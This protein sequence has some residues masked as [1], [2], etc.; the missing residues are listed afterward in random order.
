MKEN[1]KNQLKESFD[2]VLGGGAS[3]AGGLLSDTLFGQIAPGI[4]TTILSYKQKRSEKMLFNA[5][6]QLKGRIVKIE[7]VIKQMSDIEKT[8]I[9]E[10]LIPIAF[11]SITEEI[12]EEKIK[13]IINGINTAIENKVSN[14]DIIIAYYDVLNSLRLADIRILIQL[15]KESK[16]TAVSYLI[17]ENRNSMNKYEAIETHILRKLESLCLASIQKTIGDLQGDFI[18]KATPDKVRIS[19]LGVQFIEFFE[20][21]A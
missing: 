2:T 19:T 20:M 8:F 14:E 1:L 21:D 11:D 9:S 10:K 12:Q 7:D 13:F 17:D 6:E 3:L 16:K 18:S 15:Y 5:M 4:A